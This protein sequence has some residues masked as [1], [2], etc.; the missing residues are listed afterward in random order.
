MK[1]KLQWLKFFENKISD[2]NDEPLPI[3]KLIKR[4][5]EN[6]KSQPL[7]YR[8]VW[9][10]RLTGWI[11]VCIAGLIGAITQIINYIK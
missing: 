8:I 4:F 7:Q 11:F 9:T 10:I 2:K 1:K 5:R 3:R 6:F